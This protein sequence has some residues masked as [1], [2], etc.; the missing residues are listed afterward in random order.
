MTD[1][2]PVDRSKFLDQ[3]GFGFPEDGKVVELRLI[4]KNGKVALV[5]V[6]FGDLSNLVLRIQ[7]AAGQAW[8]LQ[9]QALGGVDP[10]LVHPITVS[11]VDSLQGAYSTTGEPMMT[12]VL[13]SGLRIDLGL[14]LED[15]PALIESLEQLTASRLQGK[16]PDN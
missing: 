7:Q 3:I 6:E 2:K 14:P 1:Q 9:T 12:V 5:P 13:K 10:R 16:Q 8:D 15:I 4:R 11:V